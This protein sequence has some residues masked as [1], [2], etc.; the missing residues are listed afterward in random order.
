MKSNAAP[1]AKSTG[2]RALTS[3]LGARFEPQLSP[4]LTIAFPFVGK[5]GQPTGGL[6]YEAQN[7]LY[8]VPTC[9]RRVAAAA[10]G[11]TTASD[12]DEW[13]EK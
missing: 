13:R 6:Q 7:V 3:E 10:R 1:K 5:Q 12:G 8:P 4:D 2:A 11:K 9:G